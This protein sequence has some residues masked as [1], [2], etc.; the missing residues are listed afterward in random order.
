M[1]QPVESKYIVWIKFDYWESKKLNL[2][3][4]ILMKI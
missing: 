3:G 2:Y 1:I 4:A